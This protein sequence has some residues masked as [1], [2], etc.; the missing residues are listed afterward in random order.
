MGI[1]EP[2]SA[3]AT[4]TMK[5]NMDATNQPHTMPAG[6]AGME[7][8]SVDAIDGRSPIILK[9]M[10]KTSTMVKLR[11]SSCLYPSLADVLRRQH[12]LT[13]SRAD[14]EYSPR[15]SASAS[16]ARRALSGTLERLLVDF[17]KSML[18][19]APVVEVMIPIW[20][21]QVSLLKSEE[22]ENEKC[23]RM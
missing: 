7:K 8:E 23:G 9:A 3:I 19:S 1:A 18:I 2:R 10:P 15:S 4:P 12:G 20:C 13:T 11:R 21:Q 17:S 14:L 6:P 16:L 5:I 22:E